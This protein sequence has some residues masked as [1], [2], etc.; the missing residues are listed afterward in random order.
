MKMVTEI[1]CFKAAG[2]LIEVISFSRPPAIG[3]LA[4]IIS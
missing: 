1:E 3:R 4:T 2:L